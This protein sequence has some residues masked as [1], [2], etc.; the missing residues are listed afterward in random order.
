MNNPLF[1]CSRHALLFVLAL[2]LAL[3]GIYAQ[4]GKA[5]TLRIQFQRGRNSATL[6]GKLRS[7]EQTEYS[8]GAKKDQKLIIGLDATPSGSITVKAK[9][10]DGADLKLK[11]ESKQ[12]WSAVLPKDGDYEIWV[13]RAS[14]KPGTSKYK[15]T[16]TIK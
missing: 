16:V 7:G 10:S 13:I 9:D 1:K 2:S 5:M 8:A 14:N 15:L 11:A 3:P 4:G 12:Q 6:D